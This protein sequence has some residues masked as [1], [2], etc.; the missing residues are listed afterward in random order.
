MSPKN[1]GLNLELLIIS[2]RDH[3]TY[4]ITHKLI[5]SMKLNP[6]GLDNS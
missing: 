5:S 1:Y 4:K 3:Y 6:K 2:I